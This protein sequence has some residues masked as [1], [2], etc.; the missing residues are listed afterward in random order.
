MNSHVRVKLR[1]SFQQMV[2]SLRMRFM[3][4][5]DLSQW[6]LSD[7]LRPGDVVVL[8][9]DAA[10]LSAG[11][12]SAWALHNSTTQIATVVLLSP[13]RPEDASTAE[14]VSAVDS[15]R[16]LF[17]PGV[18][19]L[20]LP[21]LHSTMMSTLSLVVRQHLDRLNVTLGKLRG[22]GDGQ[23]QPS[24]TISAPRIAQRRASRQRAPAA[25]GG[26]PDACIPRPSTAVGKH[27]L[28]VVCGGGVGSP[29][30]VGTIAVRML[31]ALK[32]R[33]SLVCG[34]AEVSR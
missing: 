11:R 28:I 5:M 8:E 29:S 23:E 22:V 10:R 18:I 7:R 1:R 27:A 4:T 9:A 19:L 2:S 25:S 13:N 3:W 15:S 32:M 21:V 31:Q 12:T 26:E 34:E 17:P 14:I 33:V 24:Q 6:M 16:H 20:R 30:V